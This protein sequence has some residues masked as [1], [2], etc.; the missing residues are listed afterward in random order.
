M[1][2]RPTTEYI[3]IENSFKRSRMTF[4]FPFMITDMT[5]ANLTKALKYVMDWSQDTYLPVIEEWFEYL[6]ADAHETWSIAC[7]S[8]VDGYKDVEYYKRDPKVKPDEIK[9][10]KAVN[11]AL[12]DSIKRAKSW[13]EKLVRKYEVYK[14]IKVNKGY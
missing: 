7:R 12:K 4:N 1:P 5:Q 8:F 10:M 11:T 13:Y 9:H 3:K 14:D 2:D 6:I